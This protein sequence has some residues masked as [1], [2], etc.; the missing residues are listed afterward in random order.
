MKTS[1]K[2]MYFAFF[3]SA[4]TC[5][6][7]NI[8]M[9]RAIPPMGHDTWTFLPKSRTLTTE[10]NAARKMIQYKCEVRLHFNGKHIE[11]DIFYCKPPKTKQ[12]TIMAIFHRRTVERNI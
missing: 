8:F 3:I 10:I 11:N 7:L 6:P 2:L 9:K 4:T 5:F 12:K 1:S